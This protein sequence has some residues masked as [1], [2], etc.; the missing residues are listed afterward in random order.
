MESITSQPPNNG[1]VQRDD[2]YRKR[3]LQSELPLLS[4]TAKPVLF[5]AHIANQ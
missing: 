4:D 1:G 5:Q 3:I 2:D